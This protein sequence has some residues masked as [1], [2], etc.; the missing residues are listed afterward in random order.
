MTAGLSLPSPREWWGGVGG[1]GA[2]RHSLMQRFLRIDPHP[3][4]LPATRKGAWREGRLLRIASRSRR[5]FRA[6][7]AINFP[8]SWKR[9]RRECRAPDAPDSRVC[10]GSERRTRVCQV[11]P[12]IARHSPRNG[13]TAS[14]ALSPVTGFLATVAP[15]KFAS[16]ELDASTGASGP[17]DFSVRIRRARLAA[18]SAS[19]ASRPALMTLRN[20]PPRNRT[21]EVLG[22]IWVSEK[23]KYFFGEGWTRHNRKAA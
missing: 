16:Q 14:F 1:G 6:S 23:Q 5:G 15:E 18:P 22:L 4:P 12:E 20:A 13:L 19:T 7:F 9:G 11:T 17:H 2:V 3:R 8:P 10:N 21:G